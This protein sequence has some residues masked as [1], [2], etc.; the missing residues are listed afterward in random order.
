MMQ[1]CIPRILFL[2]FL[3]IV[4][5]NIPRALQLS[6]LS[7]GMANKLTWYFLFLLLEIYIFQKFKFHV[8]IYEEIETIKYC[9]ALIMVSL[10]STGLGLLQYPYWD[11]VMQGP[12]SQMEKLPAVVRWLHMHGFMINEKELI[13]VWLIIRCIKLAVSEVI[14]TFGFSFVIYY[15]IRQNFGRYLSLLHKSI[16]CALVMMIGYSIIELFFLAGNHVATDLLSVI[17]PFLHPINTNHGWWPPLLWNG[18]LRSLLSEPSR[19]GN[20]AA[21]ALPLLWS[22]FLNGGKTH[23]TLK[24]CI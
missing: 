20:Y 13:Q 18:Q 10:I 4:F 21:F 5:E 16:V 12:I 22:I 23:T 7:S 11:L 14:Y 1:Q 17:N 15:F 2:S 8:Q 9:S 19:I 6:T 3:T 24:V